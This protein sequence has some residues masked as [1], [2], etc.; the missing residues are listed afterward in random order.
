M[1]ESTSG[2]GFA[3]LA[4]CSWFEF[5]DL[6]WWCYLGKFWIFG[7]RNFTKGN[8]SVGLALVFIDLFQTL[9]ALFPSFPNVNHEQHA[10]VTSSSKS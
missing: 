5:L 8:G 4:V 9:P 10:S 7:E 1:S 3:R 6:K 2:R